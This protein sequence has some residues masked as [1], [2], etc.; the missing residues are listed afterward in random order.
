MIDIGKG[1]MV[2]FP[3]RPWVFLIKGYGEIRVQKSNTRIN[4]VT[5]EQ[6]EIMVKALKTKKDV[7]DGQKHNL[8]DVEDAPTRK[9]RTTRR[10]S[11]R[12][13]KGSENT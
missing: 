8:A 3:D 10:G 13:S 2:D 4:G 6:L 5:K 7:G 1:V 9:N 12:S 11:G